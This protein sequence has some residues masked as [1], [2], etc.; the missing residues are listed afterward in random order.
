MFYLVFPDMECSQLLKLLRI[1][2]L[3][4]CI[5]LP[6]GKNF[7]YKGLA[8]HIRGFFGDLLTMIE[9]YRSFR[10]TWLVSG[11]VYPMWTLVLGRGLLSVSR[12]WLSIGR[13]GLLEPSNRG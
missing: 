10:L 4:N 9:I 7:L 11:S 1:R 6:M 2:Y 12:M 3:M 5:R 8:F 13:L